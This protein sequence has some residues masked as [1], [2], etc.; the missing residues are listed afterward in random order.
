MKRIDGFPVAAE[1]EEDE[2]FGG[3]N[4]CVFG[5]VAEDVFE[6]LEGIGE[7]AVAAEG[8]A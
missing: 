2:A 5:A 6:G 3:E 8:M 7:V 1:L 4:S